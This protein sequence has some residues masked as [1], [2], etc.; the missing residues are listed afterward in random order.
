MCRHMNTAVLPVRALNQ[1]E[2][3]C[4]DK[5]T[6]LNVIYMLCALFVIM[7]F[8]RWM[9]ERPVKV[10]PYG[11]FEQLL[12]DKEIAEVCVR[13]DSLEGKLEKPLPDGREFFRH[14]SGRPATGRWP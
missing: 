3:G 9:T 5:R 13:P 12:K 8:Q 7:L 6:K 14:N 11:E 10:L 4:M 1:G 2:G